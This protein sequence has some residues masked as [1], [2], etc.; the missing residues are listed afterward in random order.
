MY[1]VFWASNG[2][3]LHAG[4][5]KWLLISQNQKEIMYLVAYPVLRLM[6]L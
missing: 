5:K 1:D 3:R 4:M 6:R 2:N